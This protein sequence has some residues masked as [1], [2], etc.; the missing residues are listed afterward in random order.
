[1]TIPRATTAAPVIGL[2]AACL[3]GADLPGRAKAPGGAADAR[4]SA[5]ERAAHDPELASKTI[6]FWEKRAKRD[7]EGF[8]EWRE[9]AGAYLARQRETGDIADAVKA[10][11]AARRSL[12]ISTHRNVPALSRLSRSLLTQHRFPEALKVATLAASLDP[13]ANRLVTDIQMELGNYDD[14]ERALAV[15]PPKAEDLNH[16]ALRARLEDVNG[17]SKA[18]QR[19][20]RE[21]CEV[22]ADRPD[23][24]AETVAWASTMLGHSLIDAGKLDEGERACR[25]ALAVFPTDYRAMTGLAEAAAWRGDW[26]ATA[27]W[28]G[29]AVKISAQNPEALRLLGEAKAKQGDAKGAEAE[30]ARLKALCHSFPR[31]YDRHWIMFCADEG[32]DLDEALKLARKDLELRKD[33]FAYDTLAWASF[34]KG[35]LPEAEQAISKAIARGTQ[36]APLYYHAGLIAKASGDP[37]RSEAFLSQSRKLNP[38]LLKSVKRD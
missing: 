10:E 13:E 26:K 37:A 27:D 6:A 32:R 35:L 2:L 24:P 5:A 31:I 28:A 17:R 20:L 15:D 19:L 23:M 7:P 29:K 14:A 38:Y 30:Y 11:D 18:A 3:M 8:I 1:M 36:S 33:V 12:K 34:K 21:A 16:L 25:Q 22:A 9:V 4:P